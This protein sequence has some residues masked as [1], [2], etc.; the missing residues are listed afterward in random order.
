[1]KLKNVRPRFCDEL[2][3]LITYDDVSDNVGLRSMYDNI[4]T[5]IEM[6]KVLEHL[7]RVLTVDVSANQH[8]SHSRYTTGCSHTT[9]VIPVFVLN[10]TSSYVKI[11]WVQDDEK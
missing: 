5:K 1:M 3:L 8:E 9:V 2:A 10:Y 4:Y 7:W 11:C 6:L